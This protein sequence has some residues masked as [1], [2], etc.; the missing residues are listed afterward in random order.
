MIAR[1]RNRMTAWLGLFAMWLIFFAPIVSQS[2][3]AL[4]LN[5]PFVSICSAGGQADSVDH[6]PA[7]HLNA[8]GY[9]DLLMNHGLAAPPALPPLPVVERYGIAP[10]AAVP[11]LVTRGRF[12]SGRP[13]DSP[14]LV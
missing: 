7:S 13:R 10:P 9:C 1:S 2:L 5:L 3:V 12:P 11:A 14:R 8:C 4:D 6:S